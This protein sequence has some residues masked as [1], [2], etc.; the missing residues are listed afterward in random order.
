MVRIVIKC[1]C[2]T[3]T[4]SWMSYAHWRNVFTLFFVQ[5]SIS[6]IPV[7]GFTQVCLVELG[8]C[9]IFLLRH[10][11]VGI[12]TGYRLNDRQVGV[13]VPVGSTIFTSPCRPDRLWG[14]PTSCTKGTGGSFPTLKR[15]RREPDHSAPRSAEVKKMW[16][17]TST[18]RCVFKSLYLIS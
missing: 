15:P 1:L 10:S 17:Y 4:G 11:A 3:S 6:L 13:R 12:E 16:I 14:P 2:S 9:I 5:W 18:P 7:L 8:R